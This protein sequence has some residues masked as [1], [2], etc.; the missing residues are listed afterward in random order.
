MTCG[1]D[2]MHKQGFVQQLLKGLLAASCDCIP[3][4]MER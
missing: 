1:F 4:K 3:A 2:R